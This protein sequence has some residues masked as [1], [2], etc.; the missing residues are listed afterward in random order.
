MGILIEAAGLVGEFVQIPLRE[1]HVF[2]VSLFVPGIL[3][4]SRSHGIELK[5]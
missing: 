3:R 2:L 5:C 4:R 1:L